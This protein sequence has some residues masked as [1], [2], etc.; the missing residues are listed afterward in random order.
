MMQSKKPE[1]LSREDIGQGYFR[2]WWKVPYL[3]NHHGT[4]ILS[5]QWEFDLESGM[6][7][8]LTIRG[9]YAFSWE[10]NEKELEANI[11]HMKEAVTRSIPLYDK[12]MLELEKQ[13]KEMKEREEEKIREEEEFK[14]KVEKLLE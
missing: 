4:I 1:F 8:E 14:K 7:P 9:D 10:T 2:M 3:Q 12:K 5:E 11:N 13:R 6:S